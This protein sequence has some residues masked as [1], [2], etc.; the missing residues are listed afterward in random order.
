MT[1]PGRGANFGWP[2]FEGTLV[3]DTTVSC[4]RASAASS[5]TRGKAGPVRS[6]AGVVVR[7][8][9]LPILAGRYLYGDFCTGAI[10]TIVVAEG[11]VTDSG[12]L[13]LVVPALAS[14]G[15]DALGRVYV[16]SLSGDVYRLDPR[17]AP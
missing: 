17:P 13:G 2:C 8:A 4:D 14:F 6:S 15:V 12:S 7:D 11:R 16:M 3:F 10:T 5:S 1:R 9:R